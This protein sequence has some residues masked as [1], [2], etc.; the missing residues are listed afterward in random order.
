MTH[1]DFLRVEGQLA[2]LAGGAGRECCQ[3]SNIC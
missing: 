1:G 3:G 2:V